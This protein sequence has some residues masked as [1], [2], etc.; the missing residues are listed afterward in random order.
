MSARDADLTTPLLAAEAFAA[1]DIG[2]AV[3]NNS[4]IAIA[5]GGGSQGANQLLAIL[6]IVTETAASGDPVSVQ[7]N[8]I[9]DC[10]LAGTGGVSIGDY[11]V[12]EDGTG[13]LI[14]V[15][16]DT[17]AAGPNYIVGQALTAASADGRFSL[18]LDARSV[19]LEPT[20]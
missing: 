14:T 7:R 13:K 18:D 19:H 2:K 3:Y 1:G 17:V 20:P 6:G 10:A 9:C 15:D 16:E 8:G 4:G 11:V 5:D 12:A